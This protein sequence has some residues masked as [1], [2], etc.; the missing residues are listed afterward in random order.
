MFSSDVSQNSESSYS[1]SFSRGCGGVSACHLPSPY[2]ADCTRPLFK[3]SVGSR[4][5]GKNGKQLSLEHHHTPLQAHWNRLLESGA[6]TPELARIKS[7]IDDIHEVMVDNIGE[8]GGC[9]SMLFCSIDKLLARSE[10][11]GLLVDRSEQL[12]HEAV[13]FRRQV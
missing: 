12:H 3:S 8:G 10:K 13:Q 2:S 1:V 6:L 5:T 11:I 9:G 7:Q 4:P